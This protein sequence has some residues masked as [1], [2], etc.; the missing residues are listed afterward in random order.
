MLSRAERDRVVEL[1]KKGYTLA[2]I[3][4]MMPGVSRSHIRGVLW[5][6]GLIGKGRSPDVGRTSA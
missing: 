5:S 1:G 3:Q 6:E 4:A 2:Q